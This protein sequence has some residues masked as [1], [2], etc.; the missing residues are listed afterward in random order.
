MFWN[1]IVRLG[2]TG[3]SLMDMKSMICHRIHLY[4]MQ[5]C[6]IIETKGICKG[7]NGVR[8]GNKSSYIDR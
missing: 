7:L 2:E 1:V 5:C 3:K 8:N 4:S 6:Q